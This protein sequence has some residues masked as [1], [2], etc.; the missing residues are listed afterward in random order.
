MSQVVE[1]ANTTKEIVWS[2]KR[3]DRKIRRELAA[4]YGRRRTE[5]V[6]RVLH[7]ISKAVVLDAVQ[8]RS[9]ITFEDIRDIRKSVSE[10]KLAGSQSQ[11]N[12]ELVA[13]CRNQ[14]ADRIQSGVAWYPDNPP[15]EI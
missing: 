8:R 4:K 12:D 13:V 3:N 6:K 15:D 11:R 2:F 5:R 10:G 7:V 1:I 14:A 9:A